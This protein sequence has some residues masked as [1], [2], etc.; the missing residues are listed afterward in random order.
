MQ[1]HQKRESHSQKDRKERQEI[2]LNAD[3]LMVQAED[4]FADEASRR[5]V[6]SAAFVSHHRVT[7]ESAVVAMQPIVV[8]NAIVASN[9]I[10]TSKSYC[11]SKAASCSCNH[12]SY[13]DCETTFRKLRM[14]LW[15]CMAVWAVWIATGY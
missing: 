14:R 6:V 13:S 5:V 15:L 4:I 9:S 10:V 2:V 1:A 11:C 3:D 8:S 12:V 7:L